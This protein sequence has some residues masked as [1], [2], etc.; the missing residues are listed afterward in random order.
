MLDGGGDTMSVRVT[1]TATVLALG[2]TDFVA[3]LAGRRSSAFALRR[4]LAL[5]STARLRNQLQHIAQPL[6]GGAATPPAADAELALRDLEEC[7]PPDSRYVRRM[8][9]F[10]DF[11]PGG[12]LG[13]PDVREIRAL[14]AGSRAACRRI[15]VADVLPDDQR[16]EAETAPSKSSR[17]RILV[18]SAV[19]R[20]P[21]HLFR[22][23]P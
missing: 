3:M 17:P 7:P 19:C 18:G 10:H 13:L 15:A 9:T 12:A 23:P 14:R 1:E 8:A 21:I 20:E 6:N 22:P 11:E 5:I 2:R 16:S 4:R